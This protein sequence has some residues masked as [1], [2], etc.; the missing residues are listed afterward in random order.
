MTPSD[1]S[2]AEARMLIEGHTKT[3]GGTT[4]FDIYIDRYMYICVCALT[5]GPTEIPYLLSIL[6][7]TVRFN[8]LIS[9]HFNRGWSHLG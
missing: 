3:Q 7:L 2:P 9:I 6:R 5:D 8:D 4:E 1:S